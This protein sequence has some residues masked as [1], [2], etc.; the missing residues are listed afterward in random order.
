M[1]CVIC[2]RHYAPYS[3]K[4][5]DYVRGKGFVPKHNLARFNRKRVYEREIKKGTCGC[6]VKYNPNYVYT[7]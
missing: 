4:D 3:K 7:R 2:N 5:F 6:W 1:I